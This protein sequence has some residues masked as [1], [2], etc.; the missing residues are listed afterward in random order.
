M[1]GG[2]VSKLYI[3]L[4]KIFKFP[5]FP[6]ASYCW[7]CPRGQ[8]SATEC[9]IQALQP[10]SLSIFVISVGLLVVIPPGV[11][12]RI[13]DIK[14]VGNICTMH[15]YTCTVVLSFTFIQN[16]F[17]ADGPRDSKNAAPYTSFQFIVNFIITK[18]YS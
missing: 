7:A 8:K 1:Y 17:N 18:T 2:K 16:V 14:L 15:L 6:I 12:H 13:Y 9:A 4:E 10:L 11:C 5:I 3:M